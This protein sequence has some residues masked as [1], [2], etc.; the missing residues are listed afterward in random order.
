MIAAKP[1]ENTRSVAAVTPGG[2]VTVRAAPTG[3]ALA[4]SHHQQ[5]S[6]VPLTASMNAAIPIADPPGRPS[7]FPICALQQAGFPQSVVKSGGA[8]H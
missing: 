5:T 1:V 7:M 8:V 2:A 3:S 6:E 4:R